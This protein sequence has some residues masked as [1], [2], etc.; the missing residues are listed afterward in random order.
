VHFL[1][2]GAEQLIALKNNAFSH[3]PPFLGWSNCNTVNN[4][5]E[6]AITMTTSKKATVGEISSGTLRTEDLL[7]SFAYELKRLTSADN[8]TVLAAE[9]VTDFDSDEASELVAELISALDDLAPAYC[10]FGTTEGDGACFG[11]WP[12][13][14]S[15]E[16][17]PHV[18]DSDEAKA[19]GEDC[20]FVNDHGNVTVYSGDGSVVLE[21]V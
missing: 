19:L 2:I 14:D 6:R 1:H 9:L 7:S 12:C 13:M 18:H 21:L 11:F 5:H 8:A 4:R 17:L 20:K 15:I 16:E 3:F 10:H